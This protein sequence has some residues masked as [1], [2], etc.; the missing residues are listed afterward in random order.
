MPVLGKGRAASPSQAEKLASN[1]PKNG[2][3]FWWV[4]R[5]GQRQRLEALRDELFRS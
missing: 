4:Q 2:W 1:H 3:R 5:D